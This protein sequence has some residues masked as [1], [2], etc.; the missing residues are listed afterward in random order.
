[1]ADFRVPKGATGFR[2]DDGTRYDANSQGRIVVDN[3]A[4]VAAIDRANR[5]SSG[6]ISKGLH[7]GPTGTPSKQ[8]TGC[9]FVGYAW[10]TTCPKCGGELQ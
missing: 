6:R 10:Q 4:H 9:R 8:C 5:N 2:M 3:P 7:T 1:M